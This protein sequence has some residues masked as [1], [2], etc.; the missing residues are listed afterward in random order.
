M[1]SHTGAPSSPR[2]GKRTAKEPERFG[3]GA[4]E[5]VAG[6]ESANNAAATSSFIPL[7]TL[8]IPANATMAVLFG[9]THYGRVMGLMYPVML[10]LM[11][12]GSP[13]AGWS[14]DRSGSYGPALA[15]FAVA[16]LVALVALSRVRMPSRTPR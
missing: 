2:P 8:G 11:M 5:G 7:L 12:V 15:T 14:Y 13:F 9:A 16:L 6:P 10:P 3:K 1:G 4:I